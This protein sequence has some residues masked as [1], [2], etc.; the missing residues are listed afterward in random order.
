MIEFTVATLE[1]HTEPDHPALLDF[2]AHVVEGDFD[3]P[4][5]GL[6]HQHVLLQLL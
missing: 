2:E 3:A 5:L 1:I 6:A 4:A